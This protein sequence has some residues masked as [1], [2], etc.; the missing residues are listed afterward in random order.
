MKTNDGP[1]WISNGKQAAR[2]LFPMRSKDQSST[3]VNVSSC[4]TQRRDKEKNTIRE[5]NCILTPAADHALAE[6]AAVLRDAQL[7]ELRHPGA[8][9]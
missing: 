2:K 1:D 4:D 5:S 3:P 8:R 7:V 6:N 9:L